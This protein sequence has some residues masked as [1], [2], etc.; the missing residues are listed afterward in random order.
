MFLGQ[1]QPM[2]FQ[3]DD[4]L[5]AALLRHEKLTHALQQAE[6]QLRVKAP[7]VEEDVSE[8]CSAELDTLE[9]ELK[10]WR[11]RARRQVQV[12]EERREQLHKEL[13]LQE[14]RGREERWQI[15]EELTEACVQT[16]VLHSEIAAERQNRE[17]AL[18]R[19]REEEVH[20]IAQVNKASEDEAADVASRSSYWSGSVC[21]D[22]SEVARA[23]AALEPVDISTPREVSPNPEA[24][25]KGTPSSLL[26]ELR[27]SRRGRTRTSLAGYH[28][29]EAQDPFCWLAPLKSLSPADKATCPAMGR[30]FSRPED[31]TAFAPKDNRILVPMPPPPLFLA[32]CQ[33]SAGCGK[34][35]LVDFFAACIASA[36]LLKL[37]I[38]PLS[39]IPQSAPRRLMI[40]LRAGGAVAA[41][42]GVWYSYKA[43]YHVLAEHSPVAHGH[44]VRYLV[45][46]GPYAQCRHPMYAGMLV[47]MFGLGILQNTWWA[48]IM[49]IP[50]IAYVGG[51][52]VPLE[53]RYLEAEFPE[54]WREYAARTPRWG[55]E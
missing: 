10:T 17:A 47:T 43:M 23:R 16:E 7:T 26:Q 4:L 34:G 33:L 3:E 28:S 21:S 48:G 1:L 30:A 42:A 49:S 27:G 19:L 9:L 32:T 51:Y 13:Q 5:Q 45:V 6:E 53:E 14:A 18:R 37:L 55:I 24:S 52:V 35:E 22:W 38:R 54:E 15:R 12:Q 41:A 20:L 25:Q 39:L 36:G 50:F 29:W 11:Q 44:Q 46:D 31:V 40:G 2:F 8:D